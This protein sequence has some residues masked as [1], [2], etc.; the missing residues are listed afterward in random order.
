MASKNNNII[1]QGSIP[2]SIEGRLLQELGERLVA[3]ADLAIIELIKNAYD[4]DAPICKVSLANGKI[5]IEDEG[6]GM[7]FDEFKSNWM[8]IATS[9]KQVERTSRIYGRKL[10]GAKG[11]G[12]FAVRYLGRS[13]SLVSISYDDSRKVYTKLEADFDWVNVDKLISLDKFKIPYKLFNLGKDAKSGTILKISKLRNEVIDK[14]RIKSEVLRIV[15]PLSGLQSGRFNR[16]ESKRKEDPGFAVNFLEGFEKEGEVD[17]NLAKSILENCWARLTIDLSDEIL[18]YKVSFNY[19]IEDSKEYKFKTKF[20]N[21]ISNGVYADIRFFPKRLGIFLSKGINGKIAWSW[22]RD[23]AGV[24]VIDHGFRIKPY[25]FKDDDWLNLDVDHSHSKRN[26]RSKLMLEN[27]PMSEEQDK[28]PS[29]N[30]MLNIPVNFQLVGAVFVE[31]YQIGQKATSDLIPAM[32]REGFIS[33]NAFEQL[34][35]IVRAGIEYLALVDKKE[36]LKRDEK[37]ARDASKKLRKDLKEAIKEIELNDSIPQSEKSLIIERYSIL[38]KEIEDVDEYHRTSK[39]NLEL[40][41]LLGI[42]SGY[43]THETEKILNELKQVKKELDALAKKFPQIKERSE[44]VS[45]SLERLE[46][47]IGYTS[48]FIYSLHNAK[49]ESFSARAQIEYVL[50]KF[51]DFARRKGIKEFIEIEEGLLT[52]QLHIAVYSGVFLNLYTNAVKAI[53]MKEMNYNE[54]KI[55]VRAVNLRDKHILEVFDNG[56]GIPESL[57]ERIWDP[58][59]STTSRLNSPLGTGMGLGL[60]LVKKVLTDIKASIKLVDPIQDYVTAFR[61]E[62]P[63]NPSERR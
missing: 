58:L 7:T 31:S 48:Q 40:I 28:Y 59:F 62:Y 24:G 34:H 17:S 50:D 12:R 60:S 56:V 55:L 10:T 42:V 23:N 1:D 9:S 46:K 2:F 53:L 27:F 32:D 63:L 52:P 54:G 36:E 43:M 11:I 14:Q 33:N 41:S 49:T 5:V 30:P 4:A 61:I 13:L 47:Q 38:A 15:S 20:P 22:V 8:T 19:S 6:H 18:E 45:T 35:Q 29:L 44:V 16:R 25:G 57:K 37:E 51:G 21:N 39:E 3:S 26:W